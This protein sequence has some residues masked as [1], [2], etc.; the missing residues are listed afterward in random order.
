MGPVMRG[1]LKG[2]AFRVPFEGESEEMAQARGAYDRVA[3]NWLYAIVG[4][5]VATGLV[6][7]YF[8]RRAMW[9]VLIPLIVCWVVW[10]V[11]LW[12]TL[13]AY[14]AVIKGEKAAAQTPDS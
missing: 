7:Q 12:R 4:G 6:G 1:A 3:V 11:F 13:R 9:F 10:L 8:G 14:S 5:L 2:L